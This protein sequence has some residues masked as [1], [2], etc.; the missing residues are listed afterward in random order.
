M[1]AMPPR[2][3]RERELRLLPVDESAVTLPAGA[4]VGLTGGTIVAPT[5]AN[6]AGF[7]AE[8]TA[9]TEQPE[10]TTGGGKGGAFVVDV[11]PDNALVQIADADATFI[12]D[13]WDSGTGVPAEPPAT[14]IGDAVVV[15]ANGETGKVAIATDASFGTTPTAAIAGTVKSIYKAPQGAGTPGEPSGF[16]RLEVM[17]DAGVF[18]P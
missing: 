6:F 10:F 1:S 14:V 16:S 12:M 7:L 18:I 3:H 2:C 13:Y 5:A 15:I 4:P 8:A 11:H 9:P 17:I